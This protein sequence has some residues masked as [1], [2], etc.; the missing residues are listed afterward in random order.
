MGALRAVLFDLG[1]TLVQRRGGSEAVVAV[2]RELGAEVDRG[3]AAKLWDEM[4]AR[5]RTPEELAKGRDLSPEVHRSA[6][7]SLYRPTEALAPGLG[8]PEALY[9]REIAAEHWAPYPDALPT[10][11][12]LHRRGVPIGVVSDAGFDIRCILGYHGLLELIDVVVVSYEHG[13]TK[14][15]PQ[16][17]LFACDRLGVPPAE[18]L[19]VGDNWRTDGGAVDAGLA[20]LLLPSTRPGAPR[21]FDHVLRLLREAV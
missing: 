10:L 8:L 3:S 20:C 9:Q 18:T 21:G 13:V 1:D 16:L 12:A 14:P 15:A 17:F 19:M 2:A 6:W 11:R 5:A 7:I 4:Q